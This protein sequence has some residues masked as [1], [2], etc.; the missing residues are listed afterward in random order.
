MQKIVSSPKTKLKKWDRIFEKFWKLA[1]Q[2]VKEVTDEKSYARRLREAFKVQVL[3]EL[4]ALEANDRRISFKTPTRQLKE[5][6]RCT[7]HPPNWKRDEGE[8]LRVNFSCFKPAPQRY[9]AEAYERADSRGFHPCLICGDF[10][11]ISVGI[12]CRECFGK[13]RFVHPACLSKLG[14]KNTGFKC[15]DIKEHLVPVVLGEG[16]TKKSKP[17]S[18]IQL[19]PRFKCLICGDFVRAKRGTGNGVHEVIHANVL[20][21]KFSGSHESPCLFGC[22][23]DCVKAVDAI[24]A[25]N[26][27]SGGFACSDITLQMRPQ[28]VEAVNGTNID[29]IIQKRASLAKL[30]KIKPSTDRRK[31]RFTNSNSICTLCNEE[32]PLLQENH[33]LQHCTGLASTPVILGDN[34]DMRSFSKRCLEIADKRLETARNLHTTPSRTATRVQPPQFGQR[35]GESLTEVAPRRKR[36]RLTIST[37]STHMSLRSSVRRDAL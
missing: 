8:R 17:L 16:K 21:C 13:K 29:T 18:K 15:G 33:L 26:L 11:S 20:P 31:R 14:L 10:V 25:S 4:D 28:I 24:S 32:V 27:L 22:H 1:G 7:T 37:N 34:K 35:A 6:I 2:R 19:P 12:S 5:D 36:A 23:E 3:S 30:H 9:S